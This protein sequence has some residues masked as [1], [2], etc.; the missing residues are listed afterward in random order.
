MEKVHS[1]K[2][3]F[4]HHSLAVSM[5]RKMDHEHMHGASQQK[6][7]ECKHIAFFI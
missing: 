4:R 7:L 6:I 2:V 5:Y 1:K 3:I